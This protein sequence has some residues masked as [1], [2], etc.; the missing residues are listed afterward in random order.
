MEQ[1]TG[2][3]IIFFLLLSANHRCVLCPVDQWECLNFVS[4]IFK[5]SLVHIHD[6]THPNLTFNHV[7]TS[8]INTWWNFWIPWTRPFQPNIYRVNTCG[9]FNPKPINRI[10]NSISNLY[11]LGYLHRHLL[12]RWLWIHWQENWDS[13]LSKPREVWNHNR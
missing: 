3:L 2:R 5:P 6:P 10:N 1:Q 13:L 4:L 9:Y 7:S 8:H 11:W 12:V